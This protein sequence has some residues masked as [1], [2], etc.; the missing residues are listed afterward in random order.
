MKK[1]CMIILV[2]LLIGISFPVQAE[3]NDRVSIASREDLERIADDPNGDYYLTKD[4]DLGG[5]AWTPIP[6]S[7]KLDGKGH[8]IGNLTVRAPG[9]ETRETYDGYSYYHETSFAGLFSTVTDA[10]VRNLKLLNAK[11]TV[12]TDRNCFAGAIAGYAS[13]SVFKNCSVTTR[14]TLTVT[15]QSAGVGGLV[16]FMEN[17]VTDQCTVEAELCFV[18]ADQNTSCE[19]FIGGVYA[20]GF[21]EVKKCTVL[22]RG[23]A[24][25]YGHAHNGGVAGM[26]KL[27]PGFTARGRLAVRDTSVDAEFR[28]FQIASE[29]R[30]Y[31]DAVI[32]QNDRYDCYLTH[33]TV[34]H[35]EK[36]YDKIAKPERPESCESPS[37]QTVVTPPLCTEWGYTTYTCEHCGYT[38]RDDYLF[39]QHTYEAERTEPTCTK[40]GKAVYT[41]I[42]CGKHYTEKLPAAGHVPGEWT[43]KK[44]PGKGRE[45][46]EEI[47]CT[48]CGKVLE[49]RAIPALTEAPKSTAAPETVR[50]MYIQIEEMTIELQTEQSATLHV[51]ILPEDAPIDSVRFE[52]S[53]PSVASVDYEGR[54]RALYPGTAVIRAYAA[55][56]VEATCSVIVTAAPK[57]EKQSLFSW[58]RC[59]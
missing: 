8:I 5:E 45:G 11:I 17:C 36:T 32:G 15:S 47:V 52:S 29:G 12:E 3:T 41:C 48:V 43:V 57:E 4:I 19:E 37:Y 18:D 30:T 10:S 59:G 14:S 42:Y 7:G 1:I 24:E 55:D 58:L 31:C 49:K 22:T 2:V 26:F 23:Y 33:N 51:S 56:G 35:F 53:D 34:L 39:P 20:A 6:F 25:I 38:Y 9:A 54:V 28:Y 40:D 13:G 50:I 16:G 27:A 46:Q 44:Q 21:G